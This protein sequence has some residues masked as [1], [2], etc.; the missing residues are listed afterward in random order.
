MYP[1]FK[2]FLAPCGSTGYY[3]STWDGTHL[4]YK[5]EEDT[6]FTFYTQCILFGHPLL[7]LYCYVLYSFS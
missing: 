2:L 1:F 4:D 6:F 5:G 7:L 3:G